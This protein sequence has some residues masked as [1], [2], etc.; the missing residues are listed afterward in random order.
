MMRSIVPHQRPILKDQWKKITVFT[1]VLVLAVSPLVS[2]F[3][4]ATEE[5][6]ESE[7]RIFEEISPRDDIDLRIMKPLISVPMIQE[8]GETVDIWVRNPDADEETS[9]EATLSK[10]YSDDYREEFGLDII[11]VEKAEN[12]VGD[13]NWYITAEIP[14]D[15]REELYD[16]TVSDGDVSAKSIQ[17]VDV[18][19]EINDDFTFVSAPDPHIGYVEDGEPAAV[20]R[21]RQ[22]IHEMN[23]I[24]PDFITMEG[25]ISDKEPLWWAS[26]NPYPTEQD[27]K[28][29]E[30]LQELEV[31]VY[32]IHGNHDYSY[33]N[34]DDP[35]YNIQSYR[36]WIN[37]HLNYTFTYGDD[38]LFIMQNSGKYTGLINPDG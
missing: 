6:I 14:D 12:R 22:F 8:R 34:D 33:V 27:Q 26:Q 17:S 2:I 19:D 10:G 35:D 29:Y 20:N 30:L 18:V 5:S 3:V 23:H 4:E 37:P 1:I 24:R 13:N 21:F 36:E 25:D 15:A 31:P 28:V 9:W 11:D 7:Q 32:I 38:H 16:L